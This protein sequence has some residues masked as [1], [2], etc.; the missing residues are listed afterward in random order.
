MRRGGLELMGLS[1]LAGSACTG[2]LPGGPEHD[3]SVTE[4]QHDTT[5]SRPPTSREDEDA[6][7]EAAE[8]T[9]RRPFTIESLPARVE[10]DTR[11]GTS[12]AN[13]YA[14]CAPTVDESG[15]EEVFAVDVLEP[16]W[17]AVELDPAEST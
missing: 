12:E 3:P 4:E 9:W 11:G 13:A 8:G 15:P 17:L 14:P 1:L 16:G 7:E 5:S 10:G 6:P 2:A